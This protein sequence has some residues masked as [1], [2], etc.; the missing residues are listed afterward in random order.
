[1]VTTDGAD[2]TA[3]LESVQQEL[4]ELRALMQTM[5]DA[6]QSDGPRTSTRRMLTVPEAC[7]EYALS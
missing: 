1:M 4:K 6:V 3:T 2:N 5:L 7:R